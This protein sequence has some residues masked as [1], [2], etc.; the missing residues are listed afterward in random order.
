M[1][2]LWISWI[3]CHR[4]NLREKTETDNANLADGCVQCLQHEHIPK[5]PGIQFPVQDQINAHIFMLRPWSLGEPN[6]ECRATGRDTSPLCLKGPRPHILN[7]E[8]MF[9]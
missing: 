6:D 9:R 8:E 2:G 7:R 3:H 1:N 4:K 5:R